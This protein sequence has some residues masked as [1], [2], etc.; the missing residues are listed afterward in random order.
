MKKGQLPLLRE[1]QC[2]GYGYKPA[3]KEQWGPGIRDIYAIH[4]VISGVG[5][6]LAN[7]ICYKVQAGESFLIFP[8]VEVYYYSD[9]K[10]PWEYVWLEFQGDEGKDLIGLT[11]LS[12]SHPVTLAISPEIAAQWRD[13]YNVPEAHGIERYEIERASAKLR[14]LLSYY[15]E[16]FPK[17]RLSETIDYVQAAKQFIKIN[18]WR[19]NLSVVDVVRHVNIER[20]YLF[21]LFK[22]NTGKSV[23]QYLTAYRMRRACELLTNTKLEIKKVARSVGY[24][25]QLYFSRTFKKATG[26]SPTQYQNNA[27]D[28]NT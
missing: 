1:L 4:Y 11:N 20:T 23:H 15:I 14:L 5:Y 19:A 13:F 12:A 3:N 17:S 10:N 16:Y 22:E 28:K 26:K 2:V 18:Y 6:Y 24:P 25:D 7:K 9:E 21:R 27:N 8:E